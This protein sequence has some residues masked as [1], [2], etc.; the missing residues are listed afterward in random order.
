MK[1]FIDKLEVR[2]AHKWAGAIKRP[3]ETLSGTFPDAYGYI[4]QEDPT[5]FLYLNSNPKGAFPALT[6]YLTNDHSLFTQNEFHLIGSI[7][8][9]Y[10]EG[11]EN[12][13]T[14]WFYP[15]DNPDLYPGK[16]KVVFGNLTNLGLDVTEN[17]SIA[18]ILNDIESR[19]KN[20][21]Q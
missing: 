9:K 3:H 13:I 6:L 21:N 18:E 16:Y 2:I 15:N 5:A 7:T 10:V 8:E 14:Y 20:Y 12:I 17:W 11:I 4:L 1:D 19:I